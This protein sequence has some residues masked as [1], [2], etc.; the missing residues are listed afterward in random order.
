LF[1]TSRCIY[2]VCF[3]LNED[4]ATAVVRVQYWLRKIKAVVRDEASTATVFLVGT[5]ADQLP[6][7][8]DA[9]R[10]LEELIQKLSPACRRQIHEADT[11][12]VSS[13]SRRGI[14]EL[15]ARIADVA[16]ER[17]ITRIPGSYLALVNKLKQ[18][19][20]AVRAPA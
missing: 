4:P 16:A 17:L 6:R 5:H 7:E 3:R 20:Q 19:Q 15:L 13:R 10:R 1:L 18:V 14:K 8:E 2:L 11:F 9:T 12:A